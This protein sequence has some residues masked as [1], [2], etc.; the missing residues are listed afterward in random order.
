MPSPGTRDHLTTLHHA[1]EAGKSS[2]FVCFFAVI[3]SRI[4]F[5]GYVVL[6]HT[7]PRRRPTFAALAGRARGYMY[8]YMFSL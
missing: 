6:T 7:S 2:F 3:W 8:M 5:P 4:F 1:G